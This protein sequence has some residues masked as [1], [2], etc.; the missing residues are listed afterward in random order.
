MLKHATLN[1]P[2]QSIY[3]SASLFSL[4]V[5]LNMAATSVGED[6]YDHQSLRP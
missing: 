1:H 3:N 4:L 5:L 6:I 2:T